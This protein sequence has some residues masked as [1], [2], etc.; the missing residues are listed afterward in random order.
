MGIVKLFY[1]PEVEHAMTPVFNL[2]KEFSNQVAAIDGHGW[3]HKSLSKSYTCIYLNEPGQDYFIE[4]FMRNVT[5]LRR[6]KIIPLV[7]FDGMRLPA[8]QDT[9]LK[10]TE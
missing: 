5:F 6:N 7:V 3:L 9:N 2:E 1:L 8:K 4:D 10:R